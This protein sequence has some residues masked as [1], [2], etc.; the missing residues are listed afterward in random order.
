MPL[1]VIANDFLV[2]QLLDSS[3]ELHTMA[4]VF[5]VNTDGTAS[6]SQVATQVAAA[7][8][9]NLLPVM[10]SDITLHDTLVIPLDG[11]TPT[12]RFT[13]ASAGSTGGH[14][15]G[16]ALP[17]ELCQVIT[18]RTS[19]RGR[20]FRGRS[21]LPGASSDM[22]VNTEVRALT[23]AQV[24]AL[25]AAAT[26]FRTALNGAGA[27]AVLLE[28]LSRHLGSSLGVISASA[29]PNMCNQR[30]RFEKVAHR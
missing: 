20:S 7:Y 8:A 17:N 24:T 9:A 3:Q 19:H 23:G 13:T 10:R 11:T 26:G 16:N 6:P 1:P 18:W 25:A 27:H 2:S 14:G 5:C 12:Q 29:N 30:R 21:Y 4:N 15:T 22:L 28:V